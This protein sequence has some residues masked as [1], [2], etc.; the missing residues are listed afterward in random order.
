MAVNMWDKFGAVSGGA[1]VPPSPGRQKAMLPNT[2]RSWNLTNSLSEGDSDV[3][4]PLFSGTAGEGASFNNGIQTVGENFGFIGSGNA[5][6]IWGFSLTNGET[7]TPAVNTTVALQQGTGVRGDDTF[8][9]I[10]GKCTGPTMVSLEIPIIRRGRDGDIFA[11][12]FTSQGTW[13]L[14]TLIYSIIPDP[15]L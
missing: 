12:V 9:I 3:W 10:G 15:V 4:Y 1:I 6:V 14:L 13:D 5:L 2:S 11:K 8:L 7:S